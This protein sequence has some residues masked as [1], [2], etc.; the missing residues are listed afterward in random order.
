MSDRKV[1]ESG[2]KGV[3]GGMWLAAICALRCRRRTGGWDLNR[4][5]RRKE[6]SEMVWGRRTIISRD[7][8]CVASIGWLKYS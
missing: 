4:Q 8:C 6:G 5:G 2:T 7:L 3:G 1:F